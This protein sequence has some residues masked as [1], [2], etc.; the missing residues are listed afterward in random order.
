MITYNSAGFVLET[1]ESAKSQTYQNIELI[2]TDDGSSDKT[3]D[4]CRK[5]LTSNK[6]RFVNTEI[7]TVPKNSGITQNCIRGLNASSGVWIKFIAGDDILLENFVQTN[8]D[9]VSNSGSDVSFIFSKFIHF[10]V[11][12][13]NKKLTNI[14]LKVLDEYWDNL[15]SKFFELDARH[16]YYK[17]LRKNYPPAITAFIKRETLISLGGVDEN[18]TMIED[19]PLWLK[20]TRLKYKLFFVDSDTILYRLHENSISNSKIVGINFVR[21]IYAIY[22]RYKINRNTIYKINF[23][24]IAKSGRRNMLNKVLQLLDPYFIKNYFFNKHNEIFKGPF[25]ENSKYN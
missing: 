9:F 14:N 4:I 7:L 19:Y 6:A 1:L 2:V 10:K 5:W 12:N 8:L 25:V 22:K 18:I 17:L 21:D 24:I 23:L 11:N 15:R 3:V 20:A 16:Q 13:E